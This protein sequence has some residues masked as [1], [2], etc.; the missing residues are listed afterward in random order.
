MHHPGAEVRFG[1]LDQAIHSL[2]GAGLI[3]SISTV[4]GRDQPADAVHGNHKSR[5][6]YETLQFHLQPS[7]LLEKLCFICFV[8]IFIS[9]ILFPA[10]QLAGGFQQLPLSLLDLD[11]VNGVIG[12]D[13][14][15]RL[16]ATDCLHGALALHWNG[17]K[18]LG[19][20]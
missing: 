20:N 19:I 4:D 17:A 6:F 11:E 16:A 7:D 8:L 13:L 5:G 18:Y 2:L 14:L 3:Q 1:G 15:D 12:A 10:E 9:A